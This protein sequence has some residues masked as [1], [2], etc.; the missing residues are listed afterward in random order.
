M[1]LES[2]RHDGRENSASN[3][4]LRILLININIQFSI[5]GFLLDQ[6][7]AIRGGF[8]SFFILKVI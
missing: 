3:V 4:R 8:E 5:K 2:C 1:V 6:C 7:R